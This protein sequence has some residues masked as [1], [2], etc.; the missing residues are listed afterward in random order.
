[1]FSREVK[2]ILKEMSDNS[3]I[4]NKFLEVLVNK[5]HKGGL[6]DPSKQP[7][8]KNNPLPM[9]QV[10]TGSTRLKMIDLE[11]SDGSSSRSDKF[12]Q[13]AETTSVNMVEV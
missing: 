7:S 2:S 6:A 11:K 1:M 8:L 4:H 9:I 12:D 13:G 5:D 3:A 10:E